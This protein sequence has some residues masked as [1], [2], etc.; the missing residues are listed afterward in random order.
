METLT[1]IRFVEHTPEPSGGVVARSKRG[2][3]FRQ[4]HLFTDGREFPSSSSLVLA[5]ARERDSG[6]HANTSSSPHTFVQGWCIDIPVPHGANYKV[7]RAFRNT[8]HVVAFLRSQGLVVR[9]DDPLDRWIARNH[10][11]FPKEKE[12]RQWMKACI[13]GTPK[14]ITMMNKG[15]EMFRPALE[16]V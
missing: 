10:A 1:G 13:K 11:A 7:R 15:H 6:L 14:A 12:M 3:P 9:A 5:L 2:R 16:L 8:A 4:P